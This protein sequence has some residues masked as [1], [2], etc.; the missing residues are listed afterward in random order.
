MIKYFARSMFWCGLSF[1]AVNVL[2]QSM[3]L[4]QQSKFRCRRCFSTFKVSSQLMLEGPPS[5]VVNVSI[6]CFFP[7]KHWNSNRAN[8]RCPLSALLT[9]IAQKHRPCQNIDH[10]KPSTTSKFD[11]A[12]TLT[13]SVKICPKDQLVLQYKRYD[14]SQLLNSNIFGVSSV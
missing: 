7:L 1:V 13:A 8:E 14:I 6:Q 3:V 9:S 11:S 2:M 4:T 12:K 5:K 10:D